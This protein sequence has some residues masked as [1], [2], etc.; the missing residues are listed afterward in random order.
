MTIASNRAEP[1]TNGTLRSFSGC[2]TI[3]LGILR[4]AE[5][6]L[7]HLFGVPAH[8]Q[9]HLVRGRINLLEQPLQI[10]RSA[11]ACG[12]NDKFHLRKFHPGV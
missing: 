12:G 8:D 6:L 1:L 2:W 11:G 9:M 7:R 5:L 3:A 4:I 10:D